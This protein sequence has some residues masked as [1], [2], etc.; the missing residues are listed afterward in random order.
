MRF[1]IL[2]HKISS[3]LNS[4][5]DNVHADQLKTDSRWIGRFCGMHEDVTLMFAHGVTIYRALR[6]DFS[7]ENVSKVIKQVETR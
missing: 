7:E 1:F 4:A 2:D 5:H 3:P 6:D